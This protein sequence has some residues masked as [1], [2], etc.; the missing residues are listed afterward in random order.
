[1]NPVKVIS[2]ALAFNLS[3]VSLAD[4]RVIALMPLTT[5]AKVSASDAVTV[6][7]TLASILMSKGLKIV[8]RQH[9]ERLMEEKELATMTGESDMVDLAEMSSATHLLAGSLG[10]LGSKTVLNVRFIAVAGAE[11]VLAKRVSWTDED[12][13]EALLVSL[14]SELSGGA[15][16]KVAVDPLITERAWRA[17]KR[18]VCDPRAR[19]RGRI[20]RQL[21]GQVTVNLGSQAG[22]HEGDLLDVLR[23]GAVV[24]ELELTQVNGAQSSGVYSATEALVA[25]REGMVVRPRPL[26]VALAPF[27]AQSS[28]AQDGEAAA[29]RV[30]GQLKAS[31]EGCVS[32]KRRLI[33][34]FE[35]MSE[36]RRQRLG[37]KGVDAV[38]T[39]EF[40]TRGGREVLSL[41]LVSPSNGAT[42]AELSAR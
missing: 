42:L 11:V 22:L 40:L 12:R 17:L 7:D 8:D 20:I 25:S 29:K 32:A 3:A 19:R 2:L 34:A 26:R 15:A 5:S 14:A 36:R 35:K 21:A 24:G 41:Q 31:S 33:K 37:G 28:G 27:K 6:M 23:R 13:L 16:T 10:K 38:L 9:I 18:E 39:G 30:L 1:M 4:D